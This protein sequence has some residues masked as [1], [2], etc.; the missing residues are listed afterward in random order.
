[1]LSIL[2][3]VIGTGLPYTWPDTRQDRDPFAALRL[4]S[5]DDGGDSIGSDQ[6]AS[7]SYG[8]GVRVGFYIQGL[9]ML[10]N[11]PRNPK[12]SCVGLKPAC[13]GILLSMLISRIIIAAL[14]NTSPP[15]VFLVLPLVNRVISPAKATLRNPDLLVREGIGPIPVFSVDLL[16][17][18][19]SV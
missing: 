18:A 10:F 1:M 14:T 16:G 8:L 13:G 11:L 9:E 3:V 2:L 5:R 4:N 17:H 12:D 6:A 15:E 19:A 7:D